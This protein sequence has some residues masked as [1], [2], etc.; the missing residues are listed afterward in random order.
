MRKLINFI[1]EIERENMITIKITQHENELAE[2]KKLRE[3]IFCDELKIQ[4]E[5][6]I[7]PYEDKESLVFLLNYNSCVI[8]TARIV[9]SKP[10]FEF[11]F[12]YFLLRKDFR[13][14][15]AGVYLIG[16]LLYFMEC[17][18][19]QQ[20]S[21]HAHEKVMNLYLKFG[22][23]K[24]G[25]PFYKYGF[26][27]LWTKMNYSLGTNQEFEEYSIERIRPFISSADMQLFYKKF[28]MM[29]L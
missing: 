14:G 18:S 25:N 21:A 27:C 8:G 4:Q 2:V 19:L 9:F 28:E 22:F 12:S 7:D 3:K 15:L 29:K 23:K 24:L 26:N 13:Q 10:D 1:L 5:N 6:F 20:V 11:Y 17:N 16:G